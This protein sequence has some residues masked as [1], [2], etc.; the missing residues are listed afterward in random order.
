MWKCTLKMMVGCVGLGLALAW[1][2]TVEAQGF[3]SAEL[4]HLVGPGAYTP[5][6]GAPFSHWYGFGVGPAFS[7]GYDSARFA[8]LDYLDQL[9]RQK[10]L[11]VPV[12]FKPFRQR[13]PG[14]SASNATY[15]QNS[16]G[17][18]GSGWRLFRW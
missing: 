11:R 14:R 6:D 16:Y 2:G 15:W 3:H 17:R 5:Y 13:L 18:Y 7:F 8:Y 12:A 4:E 9:D 10:R 1:P